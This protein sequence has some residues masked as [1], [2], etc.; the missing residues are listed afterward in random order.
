MN[1]GNSNNNQPWSGGQTQNYTYMP[2]ALFQQPGFQPQMNAPRMPVAPQFI[3][4]LNTAVQAPKG[5][6][7]KPAQR[8]AALMPKMPA[9]N[10]MPKQ[11]K[12]NPA[13]S[14]K[15]QMPAKIPMPSEVKGVILAPAN[16]PKKPEAPKQQ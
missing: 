1:W 12:V 6:V 8:P 14:A 9:V 11:H 2:R 10:S 7:K 16:I 5:Q 13:A 4:R 3:P 15:M